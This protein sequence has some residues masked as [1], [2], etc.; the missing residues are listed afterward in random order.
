MP[1]IDIRNTPIVLLDDNLPGSISNQSFLFYAPDHIIVANELSDIEK[2]LS[3]IDRLTG[4]GYHL[5]GWISYECAYALEEKLRPSFKSYADEPLIW[6]MATRHRK[7]LSPQQTEELFQQSQRGNKRTANITNFTI[8]ESKAEYQNTVQKIKDY[9]AA[10]DVY[11]INHTMPARF[12]LMG[13]PASL[14]QT[15]RTKQPV[16]YGAYIDTGRHKILSRSPELFTEKHGKHLKAKP[17]KGTAARGLSFQDDQKQ[18]NR[19]QTDAKSKAENLMIVDLLRNDLSRSAKPG[20]VRVEGLFNVETYPTLHQMTSVVKAEAREGLRPSDII[21]TIFPCG[22][23]TG[24]PKIRAMEIIAELENTARGAYC[25][26][27]GYISPPNNANESTNAFGKNQSGE[28][29][30]DWVFNVPIRTVILEGNHETTADPQDNDHTASLPTYN[31]RIHIGSG[32]VADSNI[33]QEYA[34]CL[35]K[36]DFI[37]QPAFDFS[38]IE[39]MR[40][41]EGRLLFENQHM[42]R[43]SESAEYFSFIFD[44]RHIDNQV[45]HHLN[46][47]EGTGQ[48]HRLRLLLDRHGAI[49]ITS[50]P[51][52]QKPIILSLSELAKAP[53]QPKAKIAVATDRVKS[54]DTFLYH[55]TTNRVLYNKGYQAALQHGYTDLLYMNEAGLVSETAIHNIFALI[56]GEWQTPIQSAGLLNGVLRRRLLET[57]DVIEA[58]I[59]INDLKT[60]QA[61]AVGNSVRGLTPVSIDYERY[62]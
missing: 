54:S 40:F 51:I 33:E 24:A 56:D 36:A 50:I 38:L 4:E 25:G 59:K 21:K 34:E 55:K 41:H 18:I 13:D 45:S 19:L 8:Q 47:I 62:L 39:T 3:E 20:S 12:S 2:A 35:L 9:I 10:G 32:I 11:Q 61:I 5:A 53:Q 14:Y 26:A 44:R 60:A 43:L 17:M 52:D 29:G 1:P 37:T 49:S 31:G 42:E 15:L 48:D 27:I 28:I 6:M 22:S 16:A 46:T 58:P 30:L 7:R 57:G 23:V